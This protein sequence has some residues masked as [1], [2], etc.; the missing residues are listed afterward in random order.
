LYAQGY[1][2][3][4]LLSRGGN[5][6]GRRGRA[7]ASFRVYAA[8]RGLYESGLIRPA[9][10]NEGNLPSSI[11]RGGQLEGG[12]YGSHAFRRSSIG[13]DYRGDYRQT[14]LALYNGTNQA[15]SIDWQ[16]QPTR[17]IGYFV[18]QTGGTTNRAFGGFSAPAF[19]DQ[20]N[21]GVPL[22]EVFDTRTYFFQTSAGLIY[23]Q[24]ARTMYRITGD[25]FAVKRASRALIGMQG[26]RA[27]LDVMKRVSRTTTVAGGYNYIRFSFP[28]I[29]GGS[30]I[31]MLFLSFQRHVTRN[32]DLNVQIGAFRSDTTGTQRIALSPEVA[33]V[34]GRTQGVEAFQRI[35]IL[36]QATIGVSY[37]LERS[38][39]YASYNDGASPGNGIYITSRMRSASGG[40][41]Y[42]GVRRLSLGASFGYTKTSSVG[43]QLGEF[44]TIQGGGGLT[45]NLARWW[46]LSLQ[47]DRRKFDSP[48]FTG[49]SGYALTGGISFSP[50]DIPLSIW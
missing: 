31:H 36:P 14:N 25:G 47:A 22:N 8:V 37:L 9:L 28:R 15:I 3:P 23:Q 48:G 12:A 18:R 43:L 34:L 5:S 2:G 32:L 39:L 33:A 40:I 35:T 21:F 7:P 44:S 13:L 26:Y 20:D 45:Y 41:S 10:D 49:R 11:V 1:G 19:A 38:R 42:T 16:A 27:G 29:Y 24:S 6:P 17:R 30:E 50:G 4:S 46:G